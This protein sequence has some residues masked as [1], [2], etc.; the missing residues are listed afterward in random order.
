L[1]AVTLLALLTCAGNASA[2]RPVGWGHYILRG[3]GVVGVLHVSRDGRQLIDSSRFIVHA[4]CAGPNAPLPSLGELPALGAFWFLGAPVQLDGTGH[5]SYH[6]AHRSEKRHAAEAL[7]LELWFTS[8]TRVRGWLWY[9]FSEPGVF[10]KASGVRLRGQFIHRPP[11]L[12]VGFV[13]K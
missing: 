13:H 3:N 5:L 1:W 12:I 7:S 9:W 11:D 8:P 2:A 4:Q 6:H 10:C